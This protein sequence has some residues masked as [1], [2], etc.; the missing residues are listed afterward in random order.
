MF[1][2]AHAD[3]PPMELPIHEVVAHE[4]VAHEVVA[5]EV[6][7]GRAAESGELDAPALRKLRE[8]P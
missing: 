8:R 4:V 3:V 6:L 2:S 1:R 7:P 5:H